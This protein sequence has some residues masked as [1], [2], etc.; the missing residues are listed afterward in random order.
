MGCALFNIVK[1]LL[2]DM[3]WRMEDRSKVYLTFDDGPTPEITPR[4]LEI[5]AVYDVKATFFC[6]GR[7]AERHPEL[8]RMI[9]DGGH[10][11]GN[12]SYSH[13][14]GWR[15]DRE[16]YVNDV[17]LANQLLSSDIYRPPYG[18]I[19]KS[20]CRLLSRDYRLVMGDVV[21]RDYSQSISPEKCLDNV[22]SC[23]KG[24]S[25]IVFHDSHKA[26]P[27]T[28]YALPRTIEYIKSVGLEFGTICK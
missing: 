6:L 22:I 20:Q 10:K 4:I 28:G 11:I 25:V 5:L 26:F 27:N 8:F 1:L 3:T 24:G 2:P 12:H 15:T 13:L 19:T 16:E 18:R 21:S 9:T 23:V 7:N 17:E 14:K